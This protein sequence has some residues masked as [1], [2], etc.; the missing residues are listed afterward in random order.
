MLDKSCFS[1]SITV[2]ILVSRYRQFRDTRSGRITQ[3]C[4]T[5]GIQE[6]CEK[7]NRPTRPH[8]YTYPVYQTSKIVRL[9]P[10]LAAPGA[11]LPGQR[12]GDGRLLRWPRRRLA[13]RNEAI[14]QPTV[15]LWAEGTTPGP[16]VPG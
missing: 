13:G 2:S 7:L 6:C 1:C 16:G 15:L 10:P 5:V 3:A 11:R 4:G 12:C 8:T 9:S 14:E